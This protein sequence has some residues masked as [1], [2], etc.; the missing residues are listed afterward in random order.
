MA[1]QAAPV[2]ETPGK[3]EQRPNASVRINDA[4]A[5]TCY[6][7]FCRVNGTPEELIIDFGLNTHPAGG[8]AGK[9]DVEQRIVVN[10]YTAK[11]LLAALQVAMQRHETAFGPLETNVQKRLTPEILQT[12]NELNATAE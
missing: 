6:A 12:L 2:N 4:D 11:R 1:N 10:F 5:N 8:H 7:N 9:L 3:T